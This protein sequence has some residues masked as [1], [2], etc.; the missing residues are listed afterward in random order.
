MPIYEFKC[1]RCGEI[2]EKLF[3]KSN[4]IRKIRCKKCNV[5][6]DRI[7]EQNTFQ[8]KGKCWATDGYTK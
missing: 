4:N 8:L 6:A 1:V 3:K 5:K 2:I 7:I